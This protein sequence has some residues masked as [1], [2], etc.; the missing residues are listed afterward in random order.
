MSVPTKS[1]SSR[2]RE[3]A[4]RHETPA[5]DRGS[6]TPITLDGDVVGRALRTR[7]GVR[8]VYVSQGHRVSLGS[9]CAHVLRLTWGFRLPE[10][11][12]QA[13]HLSRL[14]QPFDR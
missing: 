13:D 7:A 14:G 5:P 10:P 1:A 12:R 9:T 6:W 2:R 11:I 8:P 4:G 3:E